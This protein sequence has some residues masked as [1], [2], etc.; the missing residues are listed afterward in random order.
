MSKQPV[1]ERVR[2]SGPLAR[3]A[4]GF[5]VDLI[6]RGYSLWRA[7]EQL[8]LLAPVSRWM[9]AE[10][11]ELAGLRPATLER[12]FVWRRRQGIARVSRR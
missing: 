10:G 8:Y 2:V 6:E 12:Y 5:R 9:E 1:P 3:F 7:Q 11:L 4:N